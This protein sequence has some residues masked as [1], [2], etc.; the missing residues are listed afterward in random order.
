M[1][2]M[3]QLYHTYENN[4]G[5]NQEDS[6]TL[7]PLAH[8]NAN[9][10]IEVTLNQDG[11]F[12]AAERIEKEQA[13]TLIPVTEASAGRSSGIAP[14]ALSDTLSYIAGDFSCYCREEKAKKSAEEKFRQYMEQLTGWKESAYQHVKVD[15]IHRYLS[16]KTLIADLINA[17]IVTLAE[18]GAFAD[19]KISGQP[20]EKAMV[21]FRVMCIGAT[22]TDSTWEDVSLI[23]IYTQYFLSSQ[24]GKRDLCYL[25]GSVQARTDNHPKGIVAANYGAKLVSANDSQGFT[26]RGRFQDA[27]Q[28]YALSY[29]SSQ[30]VH[31]A[32]TWLVK[33][34]GVYVG[35]TDKRTFLC[36]NPRGKK[37]LD[38]LDPFVSLKDEEDR[39][40][41][42]LPYRKKL[43]K[44]LQGYQNQFDDTDNVVIMALDAATTGRLS[45]TY[46]N[47][48]PASDFMDRILYWGQTCNWYFLKFT[49]EKKPYYQIETPIVRR[50]A[51]CAFGREQGNFIEANDKVLKEQVQR[52]VKCMLD[53]QPVPRDIVHALTMRAST[54]LAY[55]RSNRERVLSTACALIS[56]YSR[57]RGITEKGEEEDMKLDLE[58]RDRSYLFGRLL[59][60]M[61]K[62]E[63]TTY[64]KRESREPNAIRLQSVYVNHP[65]QVWRTLEGVLNPYFQKLSPGSRKY[66]KDLISEITGK[67]REEDIPILNQS[68]KETYLLGYYLQRMEL[69]SNN[70]NKEQEEETENE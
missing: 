23:D 15:A 65:L 38:I 43:M 46:Y 67:F 27:D 33:K 62:V 2:W 1:S 56:K 36:W 52:L 49:E 11:D 19:K 63:R 10:Q 4:I 6:I 41:A 64:D 55:S 61:E 24:E 16:Q 12:K 14:H 3:S 9:A 21:R 51:E 7:T 42:D 54:P 8:M 48:L 22:E 68:L 35:T 50:I 45:I 17:G 57:D 20:Y 66:Y 59:A 28:A 44:T 58:N 34:Q 40:A 18:D 32:L 26:Y 5:K 47:E 69:N 53:R 30:K 39:A 60:V 25:S 37:T 13:V 29:E 31:S 70:N